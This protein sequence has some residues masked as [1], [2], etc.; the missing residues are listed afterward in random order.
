MLK[1]RVQT[2]S[3]K[4]IWRR[5]VSA[6][7]NTVPKHIWVNAHWPGGCTEHELII[8]YTASGL[9]HETWKFEP[10]LVTLELKCHNVDVPVE[11]TLYALT[12]VPI[13]ALFEAISPPNTDQFQLFKLKCVVEV[14]ASFFSLISRRCLV[15]QG[16]YTARCHSV[17]CIFC[18]SF[19]RLGQPPLNY[20]SLAFLPV[21][22][23]VYF[24]TEDKDG[25]I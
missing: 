24:A 15:Q 10:T 16:V 11:N 12:S 25:S 22:S 21:Q 18:P 7:S 3:V 17:T 2:R 20:D 13:K 1:C 5:P 4:L 23:S 6:D 19:L 8:C 14:Y 9:M